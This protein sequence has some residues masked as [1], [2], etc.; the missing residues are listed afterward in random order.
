[1]KRS[2]L[3]RSISVTVQAAQL[4]STNRDSSTDTSLTSAATSLPFSAPLRLSL[5]LANGS[6]FGF[7]FPDVDPGTTSLSLV[8]PI[9]EVA[10]TDTK[11]DLNTVEARDS[12]PSPSTDI[13]DTTPLPRLA[14]AFSMPA[15]SQLGRLRHP[16]R[17]PGFKYPNSSSCG[18]R[19]PCTPGLSTSYSA[20]NSAIPHDHIAIRENP[21]PLSGLSLELADTA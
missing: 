11:A 10:D 3:R 21:L 17:P 9:G 1:L 6:E 20:P 8:A 5:E 2:S 13:P 12:P 19:Q 15:A 16:W 18:G 7:A 14:R 4:L